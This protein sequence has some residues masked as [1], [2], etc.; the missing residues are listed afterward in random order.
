ML[1]TAS[2]ADSRKLLAERIAQSRHLAKSARLRDLFVYLCARVLDDG[3]VEIHEQEVGHAVFGRPKNYETALDN[4]VRVHASTLRK[5]LEQFFADEGR[6]EPVLIELPRGNYAPV[7][8]ERGIPPAES[9]TLPVPP[10]T[11]IPVKR[12]DRS[13]RLLAAL[14]ALFAMSTL[15]LTWRL[16]VASRPAASTTSLSPAVKEFWSAVFQP[17]EKADIVLDDAALGLYQEL[18]SRRIALSEYFDR[19]YLRSLGE[20]NAT[21]PLDPKAAGAIVLKRYSSYADAN[22]LWQLSHMAAALTS[23]GAVHFARDYSFRELKSNRAILLGNSTS[24]PWVERFESHLGIRWEFDRKAGIYYP[25]DAWAGKRDDQHYRAMGEHPDGYGAVAL[26]PNLGGTGSVL[27][28]SATGGSA[29]NTV[30]AFLT[31]EQSIAS[32][33]ARL[34]PSKNVVFPSFEALLKIP[35]RSR[36]P[37]D[38][39]ILICRSPAT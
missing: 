6:E 29:M 20:R 4:I 3:A 7:F 9:L 5:R 14:T 24:N 39:E 8:R 19:G 23:D 21:E 18:T 12:Q 33:K 2:I 31:D 25:L 10:E 22:L 32:L 13:L 1:Q 28:L 35:S 37:H 11:D 38:A 30:G 16:Q 34:S 36:L 15:L 26:L 17:H 27:I